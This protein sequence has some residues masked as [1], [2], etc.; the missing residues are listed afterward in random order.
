M[1]GRSC[2]M[3]RLGAEANGYYQ[4]GSNVYNSGL[5]AAFH[6]GGTIPGLA[7]RLIFLS[8]LIRSIGCSG[9]NARCDSAGWC[10]KE[11]GIG[12]T[13]LV[14]PFHL[15]IG[16]LLALT[17]VHPFQGVISHV[18]RVLCVWSVFVS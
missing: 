1:S 8:N 14:Q 7:E 12:P 3:V 10:E 13:S 5:A 16:S 15:A 2:G 6:A 11:Q 17:A 18:L 9:L 4:N